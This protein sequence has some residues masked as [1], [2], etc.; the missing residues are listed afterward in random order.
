MAANLVLDVRLGRSDD[1]ILDD[2]LALKPSL[3]PGTNLDTTTL[4]TSIT[5]TILRASITAAVPHSAIDGKVS[6][7][8][9]T[10]LCCL[11]LMFSLA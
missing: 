8:G 2:G 5:R 11:A 6:G 7:S 1:L 3:V 4:G 10:N 9:K